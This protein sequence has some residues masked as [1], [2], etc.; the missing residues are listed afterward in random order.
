MGL[1]HDDDADARAKRRKSLSF[2][3]IFGVHRVEQLLD[4]GYHDVRVL[5]NRWARSPEARDLERL[6]HTLTPLA[7]SRPHLGECLA[8]LLTELFALCD[9]EDHRPFKLTQPP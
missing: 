5:G 9:P 1:V 8:R 4:A 2:S 7:K 3:L 6:A